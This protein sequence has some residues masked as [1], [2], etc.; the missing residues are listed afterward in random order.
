MLQSSAPLPVLP[1]D[2]R[3]FHVMAKPVGAA[4]NLDCKYC[5]YL[6][7]EHLAGG[8]GRVGSGRMS[9]DVLEAYVRQ[10]MAGHA[11]PEVEFTWQGGEPMLRG[12]EFYRT[13]VALQKAHCPP[14]KQILNDLQTNGTLIDEDWCRFLKENNFWVGLSIDG[15]RDLHDAYRVSKNGQPTFDQVV[16]AFRMLRQHGVPVNTLTVVN[17]HSAARPLDVYRFLVRELKSDRLQFLPCV[18]PRSFSSTAPQFW[19]PE[20]QPMVGSPKARPG[21]PDSVVTDWSVD[22]VEYGAF[23]C[24]VFDDWYRRDLGK[25]FVSLFET[26]VSQHMGLGAQMCVFN[27]FCGKA[28]ALE[29]DGSLYACDHYV[30]PEYR[31]G[32][33]R[34]LELSRL[35]FSD[36]QVSF[37]MAK[38]TTLPEYCRRCPFLTDCW[39]ECPKN[40]FVRTPD[41]Q[42]GLNYLCP[43]L[44]M[45]FGHVK[46]RIVQ[47]AREAGGRA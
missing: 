42:Q 38:G 40:R 46:E 15:P 9:D 11:G 26:L 8:A 14:G 44:K 30:Y 24:K 36:R 47:L 31:W 18:E 32:N 17:R 13:A 25:V 28:L 22:P 27:E 3:R 4:C 29:Q 10:Y 20:D 45:Y 5:Y 16:G 37:G 21:A 2:G 1:A 33:I 41:G 34:E 7:K 6:S 12:L 19:A 39:G 23:L 35:A 43:G